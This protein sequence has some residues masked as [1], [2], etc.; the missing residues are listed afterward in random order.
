VRGDGS[1]RTAGLS[2]FLCST[3][4]GR[5]CVPRSVISRSRLVASGDPRPEER[6]WR[7]RLILKHPFTVRLWGQPGRSG[8]DQSGVYDEGVFG[9]F[10]IERINRINCRIA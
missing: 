7:I 5:S 3:T 6:S 4:S 1:D 8:I 10:G 2:S 9:C